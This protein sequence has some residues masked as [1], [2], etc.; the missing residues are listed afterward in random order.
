MRVKVV[1]FI[2]VLFVFP[3]KDILGQLNPYFQHL[4]RNSGLKSGRI[5]SFYEDGQ[6]FM[7]IGTNEGLLRYD[8]IDFE[9][10]T[11]SPNNPATI[12]NNWINKIIKDKNSDNL[13]VATGMGLNYFDR[14]SWK[15][16]RLFSD[17]SGNNDLNR[18][19]IDICFDQ[20]GKLWIVS[21]R[22]FILDMEKNSLISYSLEQLH[23]EL[24]TN[25]QFHGIYVDNKDRVFLCTSN[26][27]IVYDHLNKKSLSLGNQYGLGRTEKVYE[28]SKKNI[29]ACT[30]N[31]GLYMWPNGDL[32]KKPLHLTAERGPL[33][34]NLVEDIT[35]Y[36][37]DIYLIANRDGGLIY[38]DR[39]KNLTIKYIANKTNPNSLVS[40]A[41]TTLKIDSHKNIWIGT[42]S[43]GVAFVDFKRK[44]FDTHPVKIIE[45]SIQ[46]NTARSL[47][48]DSEGT[49]WV[50]T[51][52]QGGLST[53]DEST[54]K[55]KHYK[56]DPNNKNSINSEFIFAINEIDNNKLLVGNYKKGLDIFDK[57]TGNFS[58]HYPNGV[59]KKTNE[60]SIYSI[61]NVSEDLI[62]IATI[63]KLYE[64][65]PKLDQFVLINQVK[66]PRCFL[67]TDSNSVW[68]G[69]IR[70][71]VNYNLSTKQTIVYKHNKDDSTSLSHY[72]I[73]SLAKDTMGN[74][75]VGT[76][77]GGINCLKTD[78]SSFIRYSIKHGLASN[79]VNG[80]LIDDSN[81]IWISNSYGITKFD[82]ASGSC[83]NYSIDDDLQ[84][85]ELIR[86]S[87][88]KTQSG[89]M[90]FGGT[91]GITVFHPDSIKNNQT[92][93]KVIIKNLKIFNEQLEIGGD[94]SP[95]HTHIS[96]LKELKLKHKYS[97][98]TFGFVATNFSNPKKNRYAYMLEGFDSDWQYVGNRREATYTN[99]PSKEYIFRVKA[100]NND[101]FWNE[102]GTSIMVTILPPWWRTIW[103]RIAAILAFIGILIGYYYY[104]LNRLVNQ[105]KTLAIMVEQRTSELEQ[106]NRLL[107]SKTE[108]L[109]DTNSLLEERQQQI[110]EQ[111]EELQVQSER[112]NES[113]KNLSKS[114]AAKDK[115]LS[116]IAH[117]L[118]NPLSAIIG[119]S[120]VLLEIYEKYTDEK[121]ISMIDSIHTSSKKLYSLLDRLLQ[122]ARAQSSDIQFAPKEIHLFDM[123]EGVNSLLF[124]LSAKKG[125]KVINS[126]PMEHTVYADVNM[127]DTILRNLITNAIKFT[128]KGKIEI[129]SVE[130]N[131]YIEV[132]V[133][134]TG[135]GISNKT[136][137]TLFT[138]EKSKSTKG[139]LGETGSGL[140]LLICKEFV[141]KCGGNINVRSTVDKGSSFYFS[142]PKTPQN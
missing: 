19:I 53:F 29:W 104:R 6:G 125:L 76:D 63:P 128:D 112:L 103:F 107:F 26:D 56:H 25:Y 132:M 138:I 21:N 24:T 119:Y 46:S 84:G 95:L 80:I 2:L 8:G 108:L 113:N 85:N 120:N 15:F 57:R 16:K 23:P 48:Q 102:T 131:S 22:I 129:S 75:W 137:E 135:K 7:W 136:L 77:G 34:S 139:T 115:F 130:N 117:D 118:K 87:S 99:L 83:N 93:P 111:A 82:P 100:S 133:V 92:P 52:E 142:L 3:F 68:I 55:F 74:L 1:L 9:E 33:I 45:N 47:F 101:G 14:S 72:Y 67:Q 50:G 5:L 10:F 71:L 134:D 109:N 62:L 17:N 58:H 39:N 41:I 65:Y 106:N 49:I 36:G 78:S 37:D 66:Q 90:I 124:P 86:Y 35:E 96:K 13:I 94:N 73:T 20:Y 38:W 126:V 64:Y 122:W 42:F 141:E 32:N 28:D 59:D 30:Y 31:H 88:L 60:N 11:H 70:G 51:K 18:Q 27:L 89:K 81:R 127:L 97:V 79:H 105:K 61:Y 69:T 140:G 98:I 43:N 4:S 44:R 40:N 54:G 123:V 91:E 12:S 110:E 114:N 121:R 116:I